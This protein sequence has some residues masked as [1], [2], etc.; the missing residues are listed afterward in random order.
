MKQ[1][2]RWKK[3]QLAQK[4]AAASSLELEKETNDKSET[5]S[6]DIHSERPLRLPNLRISSL[7]T[8]IREKKEIIESRV[9]IRT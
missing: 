3:Q 5:D 7:E 8:V 1:S 2:S 9:W 6:L 4:N